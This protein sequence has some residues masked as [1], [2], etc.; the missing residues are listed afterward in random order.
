MP[1]GVVLREILKHEDVAQIVLCDESKPGEAA[2]RINE[3]DEEALQNGEGVFWKFFPCIDTGAFEV[4]A[5][6]FSTFRVR[7]GDPIMFSLG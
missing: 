4:S 2:I 3:I 7:I 6:A 1:C 5:D